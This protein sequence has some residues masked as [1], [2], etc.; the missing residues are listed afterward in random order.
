MITSVS[1][2]YAYLSRV[3]NPIDHL[4]DMVRHLLPFLTLCNMSLFQ[5][6]CVIVRWECKMGVSLTTESPLHLIGTDTTPVSAPGCTILGQGATWG[7]GVP[8]LTTAIN[9]FRF[10]KILQLFLR[11]T[12]LMKKGRLSTFKSHWSFLVANKCH[13]TY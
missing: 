8:K 12:V 13:K 3:A 11:W 1:V 7:L 5:V 4:L 9:G 6:L 10:S 2:N